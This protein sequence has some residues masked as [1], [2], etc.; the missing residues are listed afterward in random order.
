MSSFR[1]AFG[2]SAKL[3]YVT[4]DDQGT[5]HKFTIPGVPKTYSAADVA[6]LALATGATVKKPVSIDGEIVPSSHKDSGPHVAQAL[7][8]HLKGFIKPANRPGKPSL[9]RP[10]LAVG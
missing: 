3:T 7:A 9:D 10:T 6:A 1:S 4:N 5:P 8:D 2:P